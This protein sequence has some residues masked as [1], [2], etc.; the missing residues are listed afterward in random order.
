MAHATEYKAAYHHFI[1]QFL[2][3]QFAALEQPRPARR[4]GKRSQ[5]QST[6]DPFVNAIDL[7]KNSL[8]Q[9]SVSREFGLVDMYRDQGYENHSKPAFK[10]TAFCQPLSEED[11][12]ILPHNAYGIFEGPSDIEVD[13]ITARIVEGMYTEYHSFAPISPKLI[14]VLRSSLLVNPSEE[15]A[16]NLQGVWKWLRETVRIQHLSP[17][18]AVSLLK[19]LPI[20][21]CENS[22]SSSVNGKLILKP[23][24]GPRSE[25]RLYFTCFQI[26]SHHVNL[27]NTIFLEQATK[28]DTI[29]YKSRSALGRTLKSYLE[30]VQEGFKMVSDGV[31]DCRLEYLKRLEKV[32]E[33]LVGKVC[34]VY[35]Y[36]A[37]P[38]PENH[39]FQWVADMVN[40]PEI[41]LLGAAN[42]LRSQLDGGLDT[43]F[44]DLKQSQPMVSL[45]IKIDVILSRSK[46][47]Q[48]DRLE[49]KHQLLLLYAELP[50]QRVWLYV[51]IMRHLT[52][53]DIPD[54]QEMCEMK[55][56][57]PEDEVAKVIALFPSQAGQLTMMFW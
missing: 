44:Y 13:P 50:A 9:V 11:G 45:R 17:H 24:R 54:I 43:Y 29:V 18:S 31:N 33:Q 47:T 53:F 32:A 4:Q 28:G 25:E 8:I 34:L 41:A 46:L 26:S 49:V 36:I 14:I 27:I 22:Y 55:S 2:L 48:D 12:F 1:P 30:T 16:E 10:F 56:N 39:I 21:K 20:K 3:R 52:N 35:N 6:K 5:G 57:G 51:K 7:K 37:L 15:G 19:S 23:S 40:S 42:N 38:N